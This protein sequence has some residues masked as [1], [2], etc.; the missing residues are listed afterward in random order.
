[1][2]MVK[3][4]INELS[5]DIS[6][7]EQRELDAAESRQPVFD[8]DCP[9]MTAEKLVQFRRMSSDDRNKQTVS[10]RLSDPKTTLYQ[11]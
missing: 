8:E 4:S 7:E 3:M 11:P 10:L 9:E 2:N 1:M 6:E 5:M